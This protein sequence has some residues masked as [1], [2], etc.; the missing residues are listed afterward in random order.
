MPMFMHWRKNRHL[1]CSPGTF[2]RCNTWHQKYTINHYNAMGAETQ[3]EARASAAMESRRVDWMD[4][5]VRG[6]CFCTA[7]VPRCIL[8]CGP[9]RWS[10][11]PARH[12][13]RCRCNS[14]ETSC[15]AC[16]A[17]ADPPPSR[18]FHYVMRQRRAALEKSDWRSVW[19]PG[20]GRTLAAYVEKGFYEP[21]Q[22]NDGNSD[23]SRSRRFHSGKDWD[24]KWWREWQLSATII[25]QTHKLLLLLFMFLF[26]IIFVHDCTIVNYFWEQKDRVNKKRMRKSRPIL[27][28]FKHE[29]VTSRHAH[30]IQISSGSGLIGWRVDLIEEFIFNHLGHQAVN[31]LDGRLAAE[32]NAENLGIWAKQIKHGR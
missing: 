4:S 32:T 30:F 19:V 12:R 7:S 11:F 2:L 29:P 22:H 16:W 26:V 21:L 24:L 3:T 10:P 13:P 28:C 17:C 18:L 27:H 6:F 20:Y 14:E 1:C 9:L 31:C 8:M 5:S 15:D 23:T 25:E